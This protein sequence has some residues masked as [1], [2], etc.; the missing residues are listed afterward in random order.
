[1]RHDDR[2]PS[3][4]FENYW[5]HLRRNRLQQQISGCSRRTCERQFIDSR[6]SQKEFAG[7]AKT[8]NAGEDIGEQA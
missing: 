4:T 5:R 7:F 8:G 6:L 3:S 2:A 1:V